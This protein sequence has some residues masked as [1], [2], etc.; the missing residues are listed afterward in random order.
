M[1]IS[2]YSSIDM[3]G[4]A[5]VLNLPDAASAQEPATLAQ[6]NA[7]I[8][9]FAWKDDVVVRTSSNVNLAAPGAT[10]DGV[11]MVA[12]MR[13]LADGQTTASEKGIYIWNGAAIPATRASDM[14]SSIEFNSAVVP[15]KSGTSAGTQ[16]RQTAADPVVGT[17]AIAFTAFLSPSPAASETTSGIAEIATQAETDAGLDDL[18]MVTPLKLATSSNRKLKF[19]QDFGDGSSTQYDI[20][21]NFNTRAVR[22]TVY[23]NSGNFDDIICE[24]GRPSVNAVRL[25]LLSAPTT[26]QFHCLVLG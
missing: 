15:V 14:N 8:E 16:W 1:A 20:T 26:N 6:L 11:T 10:L 24:V 19:E 12:T 5:R 9:G 4:V 7:V 21:H 2:Q 3:Q 25:N 13:F 17:T 22:V 18:R 23:R